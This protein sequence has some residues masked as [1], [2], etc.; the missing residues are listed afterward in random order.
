MIIK[1]EFSGKTRK[2]KGNSKEKDWLTKK[3]ILET[4]S[5]DPLT[6]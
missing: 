1:T 4:I 5:I 6:S 2:H 3:L